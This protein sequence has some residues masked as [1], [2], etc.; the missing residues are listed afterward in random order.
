MTIQRPL[1][2]DGVAA[3]IAETADEF[4]ALRQRLHREP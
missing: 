3:A 2:G 1:P 4:V